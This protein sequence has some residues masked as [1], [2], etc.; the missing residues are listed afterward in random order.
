MEVAIFYNP[1]GLCVATPIQLCVKLKIP[2]RLAT[3][4]PLKCL[5]R[6]RVSEVFATA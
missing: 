1:I 6:Y 2:R 4:K 5:P 3:L